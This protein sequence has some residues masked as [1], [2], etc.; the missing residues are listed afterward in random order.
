MTAREYNLQYLKLIWSHCWCLTKIILSLIIIQKAIW[1]KVLCWVIGHVWIKGGLILTAHLSKLLKHLSWNCC[2]LPDKVDQ[3]HITPA[4]C[5]LVGDLHS[6]VKSRR[7]VYNGETKKRNMRLVQMLPRN[8]MALF[9]II[10]QEAMS[11]EQIEK[12]IKTVSHISQT[13]LRFSSCLSLLSD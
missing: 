4:Y 3:P 11:N 5:K 9:I 10:W 1:N 13:C 2:L 6:L 8:T 12:G 7:E